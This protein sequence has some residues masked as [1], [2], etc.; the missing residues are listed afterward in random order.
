MKKLSLIG[1]M[2][3]LYAAPAVL[4]DNQPHT[5]ASTSPSNTSSNTAREAPSSLEETLVTG[6]KDSRIIALKD[7][8]EVTADSAALL[9]KAPGANFNSNGPL[10]G[11]AQLRGMYGARVDVSVNGQALSAGGPNWMDPPLSYAPAGHL[12]SL[13]VFRGIAPVSAGQETIGGAIHAHTWAGEFGASEKFASEGQVRAGAQSVNSGNQLSGAA[14][15]ANNSHKIKLA[16]L[17]EA[18]DDASFADGEVT[19]SEYQRERFDLG[20]AFKHNDH[21]ISFDFGRNKT[22]ESGTPALPM[23]IDYI[24]SDIAAVSYHY[25]SGSTHIKAKLYGSDIEHGMT[26]YHLRSAPMSDAMWR[27]NIATGENRGVKLHAKTGKIHWG[28]DHHSELHNSNID[29]PNNAMFFVN[30]FNDASRSV[31]GVFAEYEYSFND[32]L[33]SEWGLRLN[34]VAMDADEINGTPAMMMAGAATLRDNFNNADREQTDTNLDATAKL[35]KRFNDSTTWYGGIAQKSRSPSYQERYLWLP[36]EATA[37]LADGRTYTGN[38]EL[39]PEVSREIEMG[40]DYEAGNFS[41]APRIFYRKVSDYIQGT[42]STNMAAVMFVNMMGMSPY[43]PLEFN[44]VDA[45]FYGA[46]MD[47][48]YGFSQQLSLNGVLNYVVGKRDD[49]DDNL[50]RIAPVN[51]R[52][53]LN[54]DKTNWGVAVETENYAA[55]NKVSNTQGELASSGYSLLNIQSYFKP[56]AALQLGLGIDNVLDKNYQNHLSGYNR[57]MNSD[58]PVGERLAGYGRNIY[59]RLDYT[60]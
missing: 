37:G 26:N 41:A 36:L 20:Y 42:E 19:P 50:Y 43:A 23:D 24:D 60:W 6:H 17:S 35:R 34:R 21:Q 28:F 2:S 5:S 29:N 12:E 59:L 13:E 39:K 10:T 3:L 32:S 55:Q 15:L 44:N 7:T 53:G 16:L 56:T 52:L 54:Y 22:G 51:L 18:G 14:V 46:D 40:V 11:I 8:I 4:A 9:R 48:S 57:V 33:D 49:I 25:E 31:T 58:I 30:N 45:I 47:F 27:R 1:C 38:I